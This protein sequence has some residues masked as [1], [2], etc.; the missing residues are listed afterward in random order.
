M[1]AI[2]KFI[3]TNYNQLI[4]NV[5]EGS[6]LNSNE[7]ASISDW[8]LQSFVSTLAMIFFRQKKIGGPSP[9]SYEL[10][11]AAKDFAQFVENTSSP[12]QLYQKL[13]SRL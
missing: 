12:K 6:S 2:T 1:S 11:A 13:F 8:C 3:T 10:P 4:K 5:L 9:L 7:A